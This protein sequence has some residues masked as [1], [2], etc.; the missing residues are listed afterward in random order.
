M[1]EAGQ[2][3]YIDTIGKYVH[4][5]YK[6]YIVATDVQSVGKLVSCVVSH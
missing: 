3:M 1:G 2:D 4:V 6:E 5:L